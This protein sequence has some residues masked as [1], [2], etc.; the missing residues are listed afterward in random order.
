MANKKPSFDKL[1]VYVEHQNTVLI[2]WHDTLSS[3][4]IRLTAEEAVEL[5]RFG[6]MAGLRRDGNDFLSYLYPGLHFI[7]AVATSEKMVPNAIEDEEWYATPEAAKA[8]AEQ[9]THTNTDGPYKVY[10]VSIREI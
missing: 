2:T 1:Q 3:G 10:E 9:L 4:S 5:G 8:V 6:K 7:F